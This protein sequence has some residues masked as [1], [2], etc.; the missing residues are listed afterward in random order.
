MP[1][2]R[3]KLYYLSDGE[4]GE[5]RYIGKTARTLARRLSA[6]RD[7]AYRLKQRNHR[8]YWIRSAKD[9]RMHLIAEVEGNGSTEEIELITSLRRLGA[10]LVNATEGGEGT[11]GH[12]VSA[13]ARA[14]MRAAKLGKKRSPA[15][16]EKTRLANTGKK[17][18]TEFKAR[19]SK[20]RTGRKE[21]D[22]TK[23]I[24]REAHRVVPEERVL[25]VRDLILSGLSRNEAAKTVGITR[26][27]LYH[28]LKILGMPGGR[29]GSVKGRKHSA[30]TRARMSEAARRRWG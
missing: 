4:E 23:Q 14:V 18:S 29:A 11:T 10:R 9:L 12:V 6:H 5:V 8:T 16:V 25:R 7:D 26:G 15:A 2:L 19:M 1:A 27:A 21:S 24:L 30:E 22:A 20:V 17:R 3:T 28:R 13:E